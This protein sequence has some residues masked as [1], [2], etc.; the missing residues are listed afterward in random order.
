MLGSL[1]G[2]QDPLQQALKELLGYK[3]K[4]MDIYARAFK[5]KSLFEGIDENNERLEFLG[6]SVLD[7]IV[8]DYLYAEYPNEQEGFLTKMRAKIVSRKTLNL[9]GN[10]MRLARFIEADIEQDYQTT[11]LIGNALEA[12]IGAIYLEKGFVK[13]EQIVHKQILRK[14]IDLKSIEFV[15]NDFKS[16][17]IEWAQKN[18][19][20]VIFTTHEK[21]IQSRDDKFEGQVRDENGKLLGKGHGPSKKKAEQAAAKLAWEQFFKGQVTAW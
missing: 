8:A 11:S 15:E 14:H 12:L 18:R 13:T 4:R 3:P 2:K 19:V 5:H 17:L 9:I 1:F 21:H 10:K 20:K 16:K 6:D 7:A